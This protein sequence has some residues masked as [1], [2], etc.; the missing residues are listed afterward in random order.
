MKI[1]NLYDTKSLELIP[2]KEK[3]EKIVKTNNFFVERIISPGNCPSEE[4]MIQD[5]TEL[6]ILLKGNAIIEY[7]DNRTVELKEGDYCIIPK[8]LAHRVIKTNDLQTI[9][10]ATHYE[11]S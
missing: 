10:L 8:Q 5:W 11:E 2:G 9:W 3:F 4:W 7:G 1:K 6:V